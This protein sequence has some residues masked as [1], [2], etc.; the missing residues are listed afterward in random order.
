METALN[1]VGLDWKDLFE[2]MSIGFAVRKIIF[3]KKGEATDIKYLEANP[4]FVKYSGLSKKELLSKTVKQLDP[5]LEKAWLE[6]YQRVLKTGKPAMFEQEM[7]ALGKTFRVYAVKAGS[8]IVE[9]VFTDI[10]SGEKMED[11]LASEKTMFETLVNSVSDFVIS[12]D[13]RGRYLMCNKAFAKIIAGKPE[14]EVIGKTDKELF[15]R[16][17]V[18]QNAIVDTDKKVFSK[19]QAVKMEWEA[20]TAKGQIIKLETIKTPMVDEKGKV[21]GLVGISRDITER[22]KMEEELQE[23]VRVSEILNKIM[24]DRELKMIELKNEIAKLKKHG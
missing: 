20:S 15:G 18:M 13:V 3:N 1:N 7:A 24:V 6:R 8:N 22:R 23:R 19:R 9:T 2:R 4:V 5:T 21:V 10:T 12:K 14:K 11:D 17:E 16:N